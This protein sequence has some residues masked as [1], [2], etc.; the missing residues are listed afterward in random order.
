[1]GRTKD[2]VAAGETALS[3]FSGQLGGAARWLSIAQ[4]GLNP[5]VLPNL[6]RIAIGRRT[7]PG[8]PVTNA[9]PS[10]S[11]TSSRPMHDALVKALS[12]MLDSFGGYSIPEVDAAIT[13]MQDLGLDRWSMQSQME[14]SAINANVPLPVSDVGNAGGSGK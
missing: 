14:R 6:A 3:L 11:N 12:G 7:I 5:D 8:V 1:M 10:P 4:Y 9:G 13:A 2:R